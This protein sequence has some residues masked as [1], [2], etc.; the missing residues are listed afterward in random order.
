MKVEISVNSFQLMELQWALIKYEGGDV[1]YWS[2][3]A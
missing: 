2:L 1:F 3:E